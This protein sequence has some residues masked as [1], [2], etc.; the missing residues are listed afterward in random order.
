[1][2]IAVVFTITVILTLALN[3]IVQS[4]EPLAGKLRVLITTEIIVVYYQLCGLN[5]RLKPNSTEF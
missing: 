1:V 5:P 3:P 4:A 2:E